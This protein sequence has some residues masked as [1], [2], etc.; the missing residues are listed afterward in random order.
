[1]EG[2]VRLNKT[3]QGK[4]SL[5]PVSE[6]Y[7]ND[8]LNRY[9][10]QD[11]N[12][13]WY[14]SLY[15]LGKEAKKLFDETDSIKGY[16][17]PAYTNNLVFDIDC[18]ES[19]EQ[20]RKDTMTL[21]SR[22][23][24]EVGLG[25]DGIH[26]HVRVYFS[27][28]KGFHIF[29]KTSK[30]FTP[31]E[32][33]EYCTAIAGDIP[34]FDTVV[35]NRTRLFRVANTKHAVSG[36]YKIPVS[37]DLIKKEGGA[38]TIKELAKTPQNEVDTTVPLE[39]TT[40][41]EKYVDFKTKHVKSKAVVIDSEEID[42][43]R[44]LDTVDF[45]RSKN[46][47]KC[48]YALSHGV[49]VPGK[50]ERHHVFLH[51]ANFY[52]NQGHT[53]EVVEGIL[54]GIA[55]RN[56][57]LYP[58]HD[59]F[60]ADEIKHSVIQMAFS[61]N[62]INPGGWGVKQDDPIFANYCKSIKNECRCPIHDKKQ[63]K[64]IVQINEVADEFANFAANFEDN[65]M[66]TGISFVDDY[67]KI[68]IGT[69]TLLVGAAGSGKTSLC[70]SAMEEA[71]KK[72]LYSVF[73]SMDMNK[74]I[75]YQKLAQRILG[76]S[77]EDIYKAYKN[78][79]IKNIEK[80][81]AAINKEYTRTYM[82]FSGSLS[83]DDMKQRIDALEQESG[84]KVSLVVVDYASRMS[85][86]YSDNNQNETYNAIK[87]KDIADET[88]AAWIILNQISRMS[89]DGST[90]LRSKRV[91]KGS[92]A[93]EESCSN[94]INIWRPFMGLDGQVTEDGDEFKDHYMRLFL[95]KNRMGRELETIL[96]WDG[97]TGK[98]YDMDE[99]EKVDYNSR[100]R[101]LEKQTFKYKK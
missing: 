96:K 94:Q 27:G 80:I 44:G 71:N 1:M 78:R 14:T 55:E 24:K 2:F 77:Q 66:P 26:K 25:K 20:A 10:Q 43:I 19:L 58:E 37:L 93:W 56:A 39:D 69:T 63:Q 75:V 91:A 18:K 38:E 89:G 84:N 99:E 85:G 64:S 83:L 33:K 29:V 7:D 67:M 74:N 72:G 16:Q 51:L 28:N 36:L 15:I 82:D 79:D 70:L 6:F 60:P 61:E 68:A 59:Q 98:V 57:K 87:S 34:S 40:L 13:D 41:V 76:M 53:Q 32:L 4:G 17:G 11:P 88:G 49:M 42:G 86:P 54:K 48:I 92:S 8:K 101:P 81:R 46:I 21:L 30:Q 5:I 35:Y 97:Y 100:I 62:K 3:T 50:G 90:P 22:L 45:K 9:L 95:A 23:S 47:P 73:F 65:V 12:A 31:E 52:R